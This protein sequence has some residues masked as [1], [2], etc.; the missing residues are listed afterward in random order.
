MY[1]LLKNYDIMNPCDPPSQIKIQT[2]ANNMH[3]PVFTFLAPYPNLPT[4][5]THYL[6]ILTNI[7]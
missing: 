2:T 1:L 4:R 5:G 3:L 6:E 7:L